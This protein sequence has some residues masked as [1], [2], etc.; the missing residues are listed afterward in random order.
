MFKD[1]TSTTAIFLESLSRAVV[2]KLLEVVPSLSDHITHCKTTQTRTSFPTFPDR[3]GTDHPKPPP[4][5]WGPHRNKRAQC[6]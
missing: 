2:L 1:M 4:P 6:R 3:A 5:N